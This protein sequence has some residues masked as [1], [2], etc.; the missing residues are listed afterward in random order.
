MIKKDKPD[1]TRNGELKNAE[2][3]KPVK[4]IG[5]KKTKIIKSKWKLQKNKNNN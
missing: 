3:N 1:N 5:K 4:F 2:P